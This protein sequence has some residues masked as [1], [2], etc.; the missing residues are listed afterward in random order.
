MN[1]KLL[2]KSF[3]LVLVL[4]L[5]LG[6]LTAC[7]DQSWVIKSGS[8]SV[9]IGAYIYNLYNSLHSAKSS[10]EN[11]SSSPIGQKIDDI[12]ASEWIQ[13]QALGECRNILAVNLKMNEM[14]ISLTDQEIDKVQKNTS[15]IWAYYSETL[16]K[17]GVAQSSFEQATGIYTAK[18][19][20]VFG[21]IYDQGGTQPISDKEVN[22]YLTEHYVDYEN[23]TKSLSHYSSTGS[24]QS[25][26]S[27][28]PF[29][30]EEKANAEKQFNDY[31]SRIN[32]GESIETVAKEF[33]NS[34][35]SSQTFDA[36]PQDKDKLS[37]ATD[38]KTQ[39]EN[40]S[41]NKATVYK[42]DDSIYLLY[43]KDINKYT[44][45]LTK[46]SEVRLD[47]LKKFKQEE[48]DNMLIQYMDGIDKEINFSAMRK[49]SPSM[50]E[51]KSSSSSKSSSSKSKSSSA[52][53]Q[54]DS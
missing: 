8:E 26:S 9:P 52:S 7:S 40:M 17:C 42:T 16:K 3:A 2:N 35:A 49:Y 6:S 27:G 31:A 33:Y 47:I 21:A 32:K 24:L 12:D 10:V 37:L 45:K 22:D 28:T 44:E 19:D 18:Y 50:V 54:S 46:G 48:F 30:D 39:F 5:A 38:V 1:F 41:Y 15:S 13:N 51:G 43:K 20:K 25:Y 34:E 23:F 36:T 11:T 53:S 14:G 4:V 29:T